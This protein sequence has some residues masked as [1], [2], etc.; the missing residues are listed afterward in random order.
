MS[1]RTQKSVRNIA[2][3][4]AYQLVTLFSN[5]LMKTILIKSLGIQYTG[6]SA[7]FTDIL[8]VLSVAELGFGMAVS[9]ALYRPLYEKDDIQ[10]AKLMRL[11]KKIYRIVFS[12]IIAAGI[13]CLFFL[14]YIVTGVPD[15][16][17]DIH[18]IFIFF[19]LKT[20]VCV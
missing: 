3:S 20:A 13:V 17:E 19:I 16:K 18:I 8:T 10:I 1:S 6:V 5:F 2:F 4:I 7:L 15:I 11:F 14:K 12:V 9:Y